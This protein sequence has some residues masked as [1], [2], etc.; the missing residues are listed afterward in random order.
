[1]TLDSIVTVLGAGLAVV[2]ALGAVYTTGERFSSLVHDIRQSMSAERE[3]LQEEE[4][5][6]DFVQIFQEALGDNSWS[7]EPVGTKS[8]EVSQELRL[9][10]A[11]AAAEAAVQAVKERRVGIETIALVNE[12]HARSLSQSQISFYFSLG[13]ATAGFVFIIIAAVTVG[14]GGRDQVGVAVVQ[15]LCGVVIEAV[16]ALFFKMSNESRQ[17]LVDF[18]DKLRADE[19]SKGAV[20]IT[21]EMPLDSPTRDRLLAALAL[22]FA[23]ADE[24]VL[25][26]V[27]IASPEQRPSGSA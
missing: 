15:G 19:Q 20:E 22:R 24:A 17:L 9:E 27:L 12:Y 1:M 16:A 23:G 10:L 3:R 25:K 8:V 7:A 14:L 6:V 5:S 18:F 11:A 4:P 2:V 26:A 13:A 21:R